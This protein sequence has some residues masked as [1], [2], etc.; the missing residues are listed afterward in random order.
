[1]L[2]PA[3]PPGSR[4]PRRVRG[5]ALAAGLALALGA[6]P[7][8]TGAQS[9]AGASAR[10][11]DAARVFEWVD[12]APRVLAAIVVD[13]PDAYAFANSLVVLGDDG[14]LV[15]DTQQS[16]AAA[17]A[18]IAGIRDRTD[19]PVRWVVN[20]HGHGDH[21]NGNIAYRDAFPGVRFVAHPA[22][23]A[24]MRG[25][26]ARRRADE[27]DALPAS[28]AERQRWLADGALP[29][30]RRL[31][32]ESEAQVRYSLRLRRGYLTELRGL[33]TVEPEPLVD[34]V[35]RVDLGGVDVEAVAV[36]PAHTA[37]DV[38]VRVPRTGVVGVGDLLEEAPPWVDG[39]DLRGWA[40]ALA[41]LVASGDRVW[42]PSHGSAA[43]D[44]WLLEGTAAVLAEAVAA[45]PEAMDVTPH[46]GFFE[47]LGADE[48]AAREWAEAAASTLRPGG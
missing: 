31:T 11:A 39:A 8:A 33:E 22:T 34:P 2:T 14:V 32:P 29:D 40:A 16:P 4:R 36:G 45:A 41:R 3:V 35:W 27:V 44:P 9:P 6:P 30:G 43:R 12:L 48:D 15:V 18:L 37:G 24:Y 38:V 25:E 17:R 26:G 20:T 13:R 28:I 23:V 5:V 42:L 10:G 1:M 21:V 7:G 47:R 19:V 46:L